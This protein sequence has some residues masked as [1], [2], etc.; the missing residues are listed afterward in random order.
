M[1][2]A[3][4]RAHT[5]GVHGVGCREAPEEAIM[6]SNK[7]LRAW[8]ILGVVFLWAWLAWIIADQLLWPTGGTP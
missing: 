5:D 4:K 6:P 8:L 1:R 7:E 3:C 2:S